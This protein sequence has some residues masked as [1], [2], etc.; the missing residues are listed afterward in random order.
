MSITELSVDNNLVDTLPIEEQRRI[1]QPHTRKQKMA[2]NSRKTMESHAD[3]QLQKLAQD[4]SIS[5]RVW[6]IKVWLGYKCEIHLM[7]IQFVL[8]FLSN[9]NS[10]VNIYKLSNKGAESIR[11]FLMNKKR[12]VL[13]MRRFIYA[14]HNEASA[15]QCE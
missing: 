4:A 1:R 13:G 9:N 12:R 7:W 6:P 8:V 15:P 10:S 2:E 3:E 5:P 14:A 11:P